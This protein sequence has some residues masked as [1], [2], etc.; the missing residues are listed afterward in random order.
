MAVTGESGRQPEVTPSGDSESE[1]SLAKQ[2]PDKP[3][4]P[5][6]DWSDFKPITHE[7]F[8]RMKRKKR[9]P[10]WS[11]LQVVLG[12]LAAVPIS[13]LLLW[14]VLDTDVA[15]AGYTVGEYVPWIVPEKYRPSPMTS[16]GKNS[17]RKTDVPE[18][19]GGDSG[20]RD[21][22]EVASD[23]VADLTAPNSA[24]PPA[25]DS[26]PRDPESSA[27]SSMNRSDASTKIEPNGSL[28]LSNPEAEA[29]RPREANSQ[30]IFELIQACEGD[31][32]QWHLAVKDS[33]SDLKVH[34]QSIYSDLVD[35]AAVIG[36][37]PSNNPVLRNIR[38]AMQPIG[39]DVKRHP[40]V[41]NV[42]KQGA[43]FWASQHSDTAEAPLAVIVEIVSA[44]EVD[45]HWEI[46]TEEGSLPVSINQV[47][48]PSYLAPSLIP[49]QRL[50]LL[51]SLSGQQAPENSAP[52]TGIFTACY[53]HAL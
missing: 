22:S 2:E 51:G 34:A 39:K 53:L 36:K 43:K 1:L 17:S 6:A 28:P 13:L 47:Q 14:H 40:D 27:L 32:D 15:G 21:F 10:I 26:Q 23:P 29:D 5:K 9:S 4:K 8:E 12:G 50:L 30:N 3:A 37:L 31:L 42:I 35:L 44:E 25:D 16:T 18:W 38:D 20:F 19:S 45:G 49:G 48:I 52:S 46:G 41:Q 7:Q 24:V 11:V 33:G